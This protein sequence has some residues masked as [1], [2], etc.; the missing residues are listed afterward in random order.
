MNLTSWI[1]WLSVQLYRLMLLA[2]PVR[3]RQEYGDLMAQAFRDLCRDSIRRRGW[4][5][6]FAVWWSVIGDW[7]ISVREQQSFRYRPVRIGIA[8]RIRW[9]LAGWQLHRIPAFVGLLLMTIVLVV[10]GMRHVSW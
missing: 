2:Y 6:W 7:L 5:G 8:T 1:V 9:W 3:F 4:R 10:F